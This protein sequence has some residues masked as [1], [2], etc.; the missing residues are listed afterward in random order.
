MVSGIF[1]IILK[2]GKLI[3]IMC[4]VFSPAKLKGV[5]GGVLDEGHNLSPGPAAPPAYTTHFGFVPTETHSTAVMGSCEHRTS[6]CL[7]A[8]IF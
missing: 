1:I 5:S 2:V 8:V 3:T 4:T 7:T 6:L